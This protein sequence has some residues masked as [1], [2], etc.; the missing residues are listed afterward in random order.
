M[1]VCTPISTPSP[2]KRC[3]RIFLAVLIS[4]QEALQRLEEAAEGAEHNR[5]RMSWQK[6]MLQDDADEKLHNG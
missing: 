5:H 3:G 6:P 4:P 2:P 1:A